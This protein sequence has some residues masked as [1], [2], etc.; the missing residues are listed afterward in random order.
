MFKPIKFTK[1]QTQRDQN[2]FLV[3][4]IESFFDDIDFKISK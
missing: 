2:L 3:C 4:E 1:T